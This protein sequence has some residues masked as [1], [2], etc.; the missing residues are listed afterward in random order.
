MVTPGANRVETDVCIVGGGPVGLTLAASLVGRGVDV[1]LLESGRAD[2]Q[3]DTPIR[4]PH[5]DGEVTAEAYEPLWLSRM[6]AVGGT[7][8]IWNTIVGDRR[9]A[10]YAMLDGIDFEVR[11]GVSWTGWPISSADLDPYFDRAAATCGVDPAV[12]REPGTTGR[13]GELVRHTFIFGP[14]ERFTRDLP[15]I[16]GGHPNARIVPDATATDFVVSGGGDRVEEVCWVGHEGDEGRVIAER[17]VL[18]AGTL[19]NA[20]LLLATARQR[21]TAWTDSAWLGR[22]FM[23]HPVDRSVELTTHSPLLSPDAGLF[24][25][26][27]AD[28]GLRRANPSRTDPQ[29]HMGRLALPEEVLRAEGL[30]NVS[31]RFTTQES[32]A[33]VLDSSRARTFARR[34][35]PGA[36]LR[37]RVGDVV[38]GG[39]R[40]GRRIRGSTYRLHI[41]LEQWPN[42]DNRVVVEPGAGDAASLPPIRLDWRWS[43]DDEARR[44]RAVDRVVEAIEA[45]GLGRLNRAESVAVDP[46]AHHHAGTTR[47]HPSAEEGVVD[48]DLRV[49]DTHNLFVCG[50]S[51]FPTAGVVNPTLTAVALAHRLADHLA[52]ESDE[53]HT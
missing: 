50:A 5:L 51:T 21:P 1:V 43:D 47:M 49:H 3:L 46:N 8:H 28:A 41:D 34:V 4:D 12:W 17:V 2:V 37:R 22:G 7:S 29:W 6:R 38:R 15:A 18:C 25:P 42:P 53:P 40:M 31:V 48:P 39:A 11:E 23:E 20:R 52:P 33:A 44:R 9:T 14:R 36:G 32:T 10:K 26:H 27:V 45:A 19:E 35:V 13:V 24:E 30:P 16:L